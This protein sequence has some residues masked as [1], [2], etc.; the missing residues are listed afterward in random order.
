[1]LVGGC[2]CVR[3]C[4]IFLWGLSNRP[5]NLVKRYQTPN[6]RKEPRKGLKAPKNPYTRLKQANLATL[7]YAVKAGAL[8]ILLPVN[9]RTQNSRKRGHAERSA[10]AAMLYTIRFLQS[11]GGSV[12]AK[13]VKASLL[14]LQ[15]LR[16]SVLFTCQQDLQCKRESPSIY[17][18][19]KGQQQQG[20]TTAMLAAAC[21]N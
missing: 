15:S 17:P 14:L 11:Q 13:Y 4:D 21:S 5:S 2:S 10:T 16:P 18:R 8:A 20:N 3:A 9:T 1:M 19:S 7:A 6:W 12:S